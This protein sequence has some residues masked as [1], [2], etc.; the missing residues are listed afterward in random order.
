MDRIYNVVATAYDSGNTV[1]TN[2]LVF[3]FEQLQEW[4]DIT[5]TYVRR[6]TGNV[7]NL[8]K[9]LI[10]D[11]QRNITLLYCYEDGTPFVQFVATAVQYDQEFTEEIPQSVVDIVD[12]IW[13][14]ISK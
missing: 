11:D 9:Q 2:K 4:G 8:T 5:A 10:S 14:T 13:K 12:D 6:T 3:S 1:Q 7:I